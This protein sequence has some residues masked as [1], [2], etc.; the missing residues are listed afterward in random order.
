[1][2]GPLPKYVFFL[3]VSLVKGFEQSVV[4]RGSILKEKNKIILSSFY[5]VI[6]RRVDLNLR[7]S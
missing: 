1:M 7:T 4:F 2:A 5:V 3:W 6:N